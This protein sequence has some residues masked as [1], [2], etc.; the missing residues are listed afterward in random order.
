LVWNNIC[1]FIY[2]NT[3][4]SS[5]T[6][7]HVRYLASQSWPD[8]VTFSLKLPI[9]KTWLTQTY[10]VLPML[11]EGDWKTRPDWQFGLVSKYV[12][13]FQSPH[14]YVYRKYYMKGVICIYIYGIQYKDKWGTSPK[15]TNK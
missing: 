8:V 11:D 2:H 15:A 14:I 10:F 13:Y 12:I 1:V 3:F 6:T 4:P 9:K 5:E 7:G